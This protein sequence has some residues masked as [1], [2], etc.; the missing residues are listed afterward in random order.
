MFGF[1]EPGENFEFLLDQPMIPTT[2]Y[3][4]FDSISPDRMGAAQDRYEV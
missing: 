4:R 1:F 2:N 3:K